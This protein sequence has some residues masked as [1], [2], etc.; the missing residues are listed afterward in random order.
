MVAGHAI[1]ISC[2]AVAERAWAAV[3]AIAERRYPGAR[4]ADECFGLDSEGS[5]VP[6]AADSPDAL[7]SWQPPDGWSATEQAQP[8]TGAMLDLY[9]PICAAAEQAPVVVGHLG[10]SLDGFIALTSGD[11]DYVTGPANILHLHRMRGLCDAVVVGAETVSAD[12][13]ELTARHAGGRNP[14]RVIIDPTLRLAQT[15][16]VFTDGSAR[17]LVVCDEAHADRDGARAESLIGVPCDK[18]GLDLGALLD[19]LRARSLFS[20]FVEGGGKT[21]SAFLERGLL[22]RLQIAIAPIVIGRG[23]PGLTLAPRERIDD[24]LRLAPQ[25]YAMGGDVLCDCDLRAA[26]DAVGTPSVRHI[27]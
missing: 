26:H 27:D 25:Y 24:C 17:T 7:L 21:V 22:D 1:D 10:Q 8:V 3:L 23:R 5:L 2:S 9:L 18:T 14:T 15:H 11:S 6:V 16:G 19:A 12:D 4:E 20:V 13:P